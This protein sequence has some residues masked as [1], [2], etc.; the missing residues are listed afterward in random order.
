[1]LC[2]SWDKLNVPSIPRHILISQNQPLRLKSLIWCPDIIRRPVLCSRKIHE[3]H[4]EDAAMHHRVHQTRLLKEDRL[5]R[6]DS[7][8]SRDIWFCSYVSLLLLC[9][10]LLPAPGS[11]IKSPAKEMST[12]SLNS[13]LSF[14]QQNCF[15]LQPDHPGGVGELLEMGY[16]EI[17]PMARP[18]CC[19]FLFFFTIN[20]YKQ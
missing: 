1:M 15:I 14:M 7:L 9:T 3:V 17:M 13:G 18:P 11:L 19:F 2:A 20:F 5:G 10:S 4:E 16:R 8:G 12:T 6:K